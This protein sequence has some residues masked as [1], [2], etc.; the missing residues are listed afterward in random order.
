VPKSGVAQETTEIQWI[1]GSIGS[2]LRIKYPAIY[3][4]KKYAGVTFCP[5]LWLSMT[6]SKISA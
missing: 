5:Y 1:D 3:L 4:N 6:K 2:H